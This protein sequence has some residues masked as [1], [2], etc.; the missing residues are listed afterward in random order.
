MWELVLRWKCSRTWATWVCTRLHCWHLWWSCQ[1]CGWCYCC[2]RWGEWHKPSHCLSEVPSKRLE[3][4][5]RG[6]S[7]KSSPWGR[8]W[9]LW[10]EKLGVG[11][12]RPSP[13]SLFRAQPPREIWWVWR[14]VERT[15][16]EI[17][18]KIMEVSSCGITVNKSSSLT[19]QL[20][21]MI[22]FFKNISGSSLV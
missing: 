20:N 7:R 11:L 4:R 14:A 17:K 15:F 19:R 3:R 18:C 16:P 10:W 6:P 9:L 8:L 22:V 5:F 13:L 21:H 2:Y 12:G 1:P